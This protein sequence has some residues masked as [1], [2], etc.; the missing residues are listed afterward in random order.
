MEKEGCPLVLRRLV[1]TLLATL[2]LITAA[3][4]GA[5]G[6]PLSGGNTIYIING[7]DIAF[8]F[9]PIVRADGVLIPDE[10]ARWLGLTVT[11]AE[12]SLTV[13][14]GKVTAQLT[15]GQTWAVVDGRPMHL[16]PGPV[17]VIGKLFLPADLLKEFGLSVSLEGNLMEIRDLTAG[18]QFPE[19]LSREDY[20][21]QLMR[22]TVRGRVRSDEGRPYLDL[23]FLWLTPE[24]VAS[25]QFRA[26]FRQRVEYLSLLQSNSLALVTVVNR[27]NGTVT[28]TPGSLMLVDEASGDQF[29]VERT[30]DY[31][32]LISEKVAPQ[33]R[34]ASVLVYPKVPEGLDRLVLF[35]DTN[36]ASLGTLHLK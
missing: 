7:E 35:S 32:G 20:E 1:I 9:D 33:A 6:A 25:E 8:T 3:S 15:L 5:M 19:G 17:R 22:R 4:T 11:E 13:T 29:D 30:L 31:Q 14:R 21:A 34:K 18:L 26:T 10:V 24:M 2:L 28:L 16:S 36:Q 27:S 23:E 12:K